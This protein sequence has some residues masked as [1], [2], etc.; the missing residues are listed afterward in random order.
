VFL[1]KSESQPGSVSIEILHWQEPPATFEWSAGAASSDDEDD[2]LGV[3]PK[4]CR[5]FFQDHRQPVLSFVERPIEI[6]KAV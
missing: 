4:E 5:N 2:A 6:F 1:V 3:R